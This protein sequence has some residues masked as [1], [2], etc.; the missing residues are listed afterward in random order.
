MSFS[1]PIFN[2]FCNVWHQP[3]HPPA[4]PSFNVKCNLAYGRRGMSE[5]VD[6]SLSFRWPMTLLLPLGTDVRT[7]AQGSSLDIVEVPAGSQRYYYV[8]AVDDVG[9]GFA[10]EHRA[11]VLIAT[12]DFGNWP[13]PYP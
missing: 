4:A 13:I 6:T 9:K 10:N 5:L 11:A 12:A 7:Q 1:L 3:A 2:L 8:V